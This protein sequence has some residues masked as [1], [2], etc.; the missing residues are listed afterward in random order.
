MVLLCSDVVPDGSN[1]FCVED[2]SIVRKVGFHFGPRFLVRDGK[3]SGLVGGAVTPSVG[4]DWNRD[5]LRRMVV[6]GV[7]FDVL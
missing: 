3:V 2:R 1:F 6:G 4:F 5:G 7:C